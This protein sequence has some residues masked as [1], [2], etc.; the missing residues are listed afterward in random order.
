MAVGRISGPLLKQNLLREGVNL[1][2]ENDLLYLDVNNARIG[3]NNS[4]PQFDLDVGGI[5]RVPTL[6]V[7]TNADIGDVNINGNTISSTT[8]TLAL[9]SG[10]NVVYQNRLTIDSIDIEG[11]RIRSNASNANIEFRP[12]GTGS[13]EVYSDMNVTGD[14]YASGNITADGTITI[15]DADTDEI[16]FNAEVNSDIIPAQT[17]T[18]NLGSVDAR[19]SEVFT[20]TFNADSINVDDIDL[21]GIDLTLRHGNI[22]YVAVNGDDTHTGTH[23]NDPF[24]SLK[25]AL[26]QATSGDTIHIYPG[27]YTEEFPLTVP[28]GVTVRG[29]GIRSVK[30]QPT[31]ESKY[32]DAF[33]MNGESTV[34]EITISGYHSGGRY[35][36]VTARG[37]GTATVNVGPAPFAHAYVS[38][39][40]VKFEGP[41]VYPDNP[42]TIYT[43]TASGTNTFTVNVGTAPKAHTYIANSGT[44]TFGGTIVFP[45]SAGTD[46]ITTA[47]GAGT[48]TV[49]V[50]T[51]TKAHTYVSGGT[52]AS[53]DSTSY[54]V[55]GATYDESTGVLV[56]THDGPNIGVS[57]QVF[58][59]NITFNC[60]PATYTVESAVYDHTTGDLVV[61]HTGGGDT[62]VGANVTFEG[63]LFDCADETAN[64]TGAT[65]NHTTG[66][67]V[68]THDG[69]ST[70]GSVGAKAF[71]SNLTFSCNNDTR[72]F[73][74]NGYAFRF[75]TDFEVT[76]RSPYIR[77][78]T[79]ITSGST[80][81]V[82]DPR[83]FNAG[84]AGKGAYADG[85]Y[86]TANSKEAAMLFHAV[87]FICPGVDGLVA[88]NGARIE[89]LNSFTYFANKGL[90]VFDSNDGIKG[91]GK[92][93]LRVDDVTGSFSAGETVTYYDTD[94][95][96]VLATG[97]IDSKDADG[98][99]YITGKVLGFDLPINRDAKV[100]GAVGSAALD[101]DIKKFGTASLEL[102]GDGGIA[103]S[104]QT[105][106]GFGTG[107]FTIEMWVYLPT[108]PV[109]NKFILDM[110]AG[111]DTDVAP[112][113]YTNNG[114]L[115]Y[116]ADS[117][118][119]ITGAS[120]LTPAT[121]HHIALARSGT[122]TKLF[123]DGTQVGS[124]YS[125]T[126]NYGIAKPLIVGNDYT[127]S[128]GIAGY[129]DDLRLQKDNAEYT[130][131]FT[132]PTANLYS[133]PNTVL[134]LRFNGTDSTVSFEDTTLQAQDIRFS[135]GATATE[136]VLADYTDFGAEVRMIGSAAVYGN[137]GLYGN[138]P[139]V[140]VYAI[141]QNLAYIGNGKEVTNDKTTVIQ[142]NE[143]VQ[144]NDAKIRFNSV[145][146]KGDF[147]VGN[148]FYVNQ[149]SGEV[150]FT[151]G[152]GVDSAAG[153]SFSDGADTTTILPSGIDTGNWRISGNTVETLAG[154]ANFTSASNEINFN[155]NVNIDGNLDVTGD[156]TLAG[157]ITIGDEATDSIEIIG[158]INSNVTPSSNSTFTLGTPTKKWQNVYANSLSIDD[159][160]IQNNFIT[161][162]TSN[163]D[164][165]LRA[166]GTGVI[167][168]DNIS[169]DNFTIS[170]DNDIILESLSEYVKVNST[171]AI[172]IPVG[173][174]ASR[175]TAEN[176]LIRFNTD[177]AV[178]EGYN[179]TGWIQLNGVYDLDL[180]T[181]VTAELN[182]GDNDNTIRFDVA[183]STIVT[184]DE[185]KLDA[186]KITVDEIEI[187]TNVITTI[188]TNTDLNLQAQGTGSVV[189]ENFA[190]SENSITNTVA[191]S[192]TLYNNTGD[193]YVKINGTNGF[194]IPVGDNTNRPNPSF[195]ETGM[196]R[197]NTADGRVEAYDGQQ[198]GSVAGATGSITRIDAEYLAIETVLI[199]G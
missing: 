95:T 154:D 27:V 45:R 6:E 37:S 21:G 132:A 20:T 195:T 9:G 81:T 60:A 52:I 148:L 7:T 125:D 135:G 28:V 146:H 48:V 14:I 65:Y 71:L 99:F 120:V 78:I 163:S 1:A 183:G 96:T 155:S 172:K 151:S 18:F 137:Y 145:D 176:G 58:L 73:P 124:T 138:G 171:G 57:E 104:P 17:D 147:R 179:G 62:G 64:I 184:I 75:A 113:I 150:T 54:N 160:L 92:T 3:I 199:L 91:A 134:L 192:I 66:E 194:V 167:K 29:E 88:T 36:N 136:F 166:N 68:F 193:G 82:E 130:S 188:T 153:L 111:L 33:L 79:V 149:E 13:V 168:I 10:D 101:T 5:A 107:D 70:I 22:F 59:S 158:G 106:F 87:T 108:T 80:T 90:N 8:S 61:T 72:V 170:S 128:N 196:I 16:V 89:W 12:N 142:E 53:S 102:D 86:A 46:Y 133:T 24:V 165:E 110:R 197:F 198:W 139:G 38:G 157:D 25:H 123:V 103:T 129:I 143:V 47:S 178:Y 185:N 127:E 159:V 93:A 140:L 83:G 85:A 34:E 94:G 44:A 49:N 74:D 100:V 4:N 31:E 55:T 162:T 122:D 152:A 180:D 19:W 118:A 169:I 69:A 186:P 35:F 109:A 126:N 40:T 175:P 42:A 67:L 181:K 2:F 63:L 26:S 187:D 77:N 97:T 191:D 177:R 32:N 115:V 190:F 51:T 174:E 164:L 144:L 50:G 156:I 173:D 30:I 23:Q 141:G 84:D 116:Y 117:A 105:D 98:K 189:L 114:D 161:T 41:K 112:V 119:R 182:P 131:N 43:T 121:W 56:V 76:T 11:N 15:G 39:G